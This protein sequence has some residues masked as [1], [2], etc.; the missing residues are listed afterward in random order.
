[1]YF[2]LIKLKILIKLSNEEVYNCVMLLELMVKCLECLYCDG[3]KVV[4]DYYIVD[5]YINIHINTPFYSTIIYLQP[6]SYTPQTLT[7]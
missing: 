7:I 6:N 1:M 5:D 4:V 2:K 3:V